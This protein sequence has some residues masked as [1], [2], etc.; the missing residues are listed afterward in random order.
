MKYDVKLHCLSLNF[1]Y[2]MSTLLNILTESISFSYRYFKYTYI[3]STI[4]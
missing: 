4:F 1:G 2:F 3:L